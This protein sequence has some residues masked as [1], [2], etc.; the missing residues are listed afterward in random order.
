MTPFGWAYLVIS[1][2]LFLG[3]GL[4]TFVITGWMDRREHRRAAAASH[5]HGLP[6][7]QPLQR[8]HPVN[9]RDPHI[10]GQP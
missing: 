1:P 7:E 6:H 3:A 10:A 8:R 2:L 9:R 4:L 5:P